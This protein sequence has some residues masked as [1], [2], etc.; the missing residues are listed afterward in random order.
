LGTFGSKE[1]VYRSS[2]Q[3]SQAQIGFGSECTLGTSAIGPIS[4]LLPLERALEQ[5][6]KV[7]NKRI[8]NSQRLGSA[9]LASLIY[10]S[11][12]LRITGIPSLLTLIPWICFLGNSPE[13]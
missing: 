12:G 9:T 6:N 1:G 4:G 13:K 10:C 11:K 8:S 2:L 3:K 7:V 5:H